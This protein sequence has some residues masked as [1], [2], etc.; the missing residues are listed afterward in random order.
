MVAAASQVGFEVFG[1]SEHFYRPR[2]ERLRYAHESSEGDWGRAGWPGFVDDVLA[3][4]DGTTKLRVVL[5]A[6]VE[7]LPGYAEWAREELARWPVEYVVISVHFLEIGGEVVPF[8]FSPEQWSRAVGLCGGQAQLFRRYYEHVLDALEWGLGDVLGHLDVIK[9]FSSSPVHDS[10]VDGLVGT[11][12]DRC[13][14][15]GVV[16]DLNARGLIKPCAEIYPSPSILQRAAKAGVDVITGDD[17]HAPEQVGLNLDKAAAAARDA[18]Y[19][20][21]CLPQRLGGRCFEI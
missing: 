18:G 19:T 4:R 20:E 11:I 21:V 3:C 15:D 9:I 2:E 7:Y 10:E 12:L 13:A 14:R 5:G 6:E 1:L 16:L 8:D 17:S